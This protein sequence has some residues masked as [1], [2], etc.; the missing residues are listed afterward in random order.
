MPK[1]KW[2]LDAGCGHDLI[3]QKMAGNGPV[4]RL[5][6]D[7]TIAFATA[8]GRI[9][10]EI[11]A[12]MFCEELKDLVEPL[13][14]PDTPA[15]L[16]IGRRCMHM[17]YG[18][19]WHPGQNLF[20]VTPDDKVIPLLVRKDIPYLVVGSSRS[21]PKNPKNFVEI[22][23][24]PAVEQA[25]LDKGAQDKQTEGAGSTVSS[26]NSGVA[27]NVVTE[28]LRERYPYGYT[29]ELS[30]EC[31]IPLAVLK[32][33]YD[34]YGSECEDEEWE[35]QNVAMAV[36]PALEETEESRV[37]PVAF[38]TDGGREVSLG[39]VSDDEK[40]LA[41]PASK[42]RRR[43]EIEPVNTDDEERSCRDT[44]D[45]GCECVLAQSVSP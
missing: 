42:R 21:I 15:V 4:R 30:K 1:G 38:A 26:G 16:S 34:T 14:L 35:S 3:S 41:E 12:P 20:L 45:C 7:E 36:E 44:C 32:Q 29:G 37:F 28:N 39:E 10:T 9:T 43:I 33:V 8:N 25:E 5:E 22:P 23:I 17:G 31:E 2:L 11:V 19:Y 40:E 13:V 24:V 18:F 6:N 27:E